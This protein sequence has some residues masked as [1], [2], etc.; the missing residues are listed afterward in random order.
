MDAPQQL[1][2]PILDAARAQLFVRHIRKAAAR[3][4]KWTCPVCRERTI[5]ANAA[6]CLACSAR[7]EQEK[8]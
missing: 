5:S 4:G 2:V 6:S 7:P 8:E 1:V 3:A